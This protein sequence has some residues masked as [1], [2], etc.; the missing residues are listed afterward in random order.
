[1]MIRSAPDSSATFVASI[2]ALTSLTTNSVTGNQLL[3]AIAAKP[4]ASNSS[5]D[6]GGNPFAGGFTSNLDGILGGN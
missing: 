1:M 3:T 2:T 4:T 5:V 6:V